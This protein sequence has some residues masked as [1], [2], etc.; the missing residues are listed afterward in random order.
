VKHRSFFFYIMGFLLALPLIVVNSQAQLN[1][2]PQQDTG[3]HWDNVKIVAGGF[4]THVVPDPGTP[5]RMYLRTDIGGAYR[6]DY[7]ERHPHWTPLT[8]VF[9]QNNW[10]LVGTEAIAIDPVDPNRIYLAQGEYTETWAPNG[11]ILRSTDAGRSFRQTNLPIQLGSNE[12]GRYSGERLAVDP[13]HHNTVFFGSRNNGLWRSMDFGA[14]WN[15]VASFPVTGPTSGV[16]VIFVD[17]K[18]TGAHPD[19]ETIF[20]GVSDPTTG[21]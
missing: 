2:Q 5:G 17:F 20:V 14:T 13:Q 15:Q 10:N 11:A 1:H 18:V 16:G 3:Y 21:L 19:T 12:A 8:D 6:I 7:R 4:I 9:N